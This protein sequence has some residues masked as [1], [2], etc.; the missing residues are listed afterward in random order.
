V[1]VRG[2]DAAAGTVP[3]QDNQQRRIVSTTPKTVLNLAALAAHT[4]P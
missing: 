2:T 3:L 1:T 4:T